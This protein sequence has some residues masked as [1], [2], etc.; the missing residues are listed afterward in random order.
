MIKEYIIQNWANILVLLAFVVLMKTTVFLDAKTKRRMYCLILG[1]FIFF[2]IVFV[3][4]ALEDMGELPKVRLVLMAIRYSAT[5]LII[6]LIIYTLAKNV[7]WAVFLPAIAFTAIDIISIFTGIVFSLSEDG[8][9]RRGPL[10]YLPYIMVGAYSVLL[11][12][13]LLKRSNMR[14]TELFPIIFLCIAFA[15][16]LV[17]PFLLGKDYS[18][19][20]CVTITIALFVYHVFSIL[21]LTEKDALTGL[22]NRQAFY[23]TINSESKEINALVSIDMNGLKAINDTEGH[24]AGDTALSTLAFCMMQATTVKQ[25]V[26]RIGG[27]E[28][29]IICKK[30]SENDILQLIERIKKKVSETKYHCAIGYSVC[31]E[32][33]KNI[34]ELMKESDEMMYRNKK[35]F[36]SQPGNSKHRS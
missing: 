34:D 7:H 21:Q 20:F 22:L 14:S 16:G 4:F 6:A 28:F 1:L 36:Y 27:D 8:A 17:L 30:A 35:E 12:Y 13:L 2:H 11:V 23:N 26:Y 24:A 9:L 18:Q 3:E 31:P 32:G 5:P 25:S 29:V 15:S 33:V 19:I 10:G